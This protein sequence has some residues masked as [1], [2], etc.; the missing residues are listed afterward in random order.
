[1]FGAG[2]MF[3]PQVVKS[4]RVMKRAVEA[5]TPYI[6]AQSSKGKS[7][8]K[9]VMATVKGDVHDIGKNIV[10]VVTSCNGYEI[11]DLG[12]MVE[13]ETIA[14]EAQ[15]WG[16]DAIGL[17][18]LI[19][20]SLDEMIK[21]VKCL[22]SR[23]MKTDVIIG[24]ATTSELHTAVKIAPEYSGVVVHSRDASEN[25]RILSRLL[26]PDRESYIA[27]IKADQAAERELYLQKEALRTL[28]PIEQA[29]Q[30]AYCKRAED[31]IIP[32]HTGKVVFNNFSI[33][34][35]EKY[36]DWNFFFSSWEL[37]GRYPEILSSPEK[38]EQARHLF[39]DA[40]RMIDKI[41][42][43]KALTLNGT[44]GI[45]PAY[46]REDDIIVV[47]PKGETVLAQLRNQSS[48]AD[49]NLC[50][51]DYITEK[52]SGQDYIGMFAVSAGLGLKKLS[53][54][55]KDSGDD[56]GA[57]MCKLLADRL[58]EAFAE[59]VHEF[60][61]RTMWGYQKEELSVKDVLR[62]NYTGLRFAFGYPATPDH[63]QKREIFDILGVT[64]TTGMRL[65][66]NY[67]I[68]PGEALCGLIFSDPNAKYFTIGPIS[69]QQK[70]EY[71]SR[72]N[73]PLQT[74]EKLISKI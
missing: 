56:Y 62:G 12:V 27:Q 6:E 71:A 13:C 50:V 3:L 14:D 61:R 9:V 52:G 55:Y 37:K 59:T 63:S 36:I 41:K 20:P 38:G 54:G 65:T 68:D 66:E 1:M 72:R 49:Q 17:S 58:T 51:A 29:R 11:K 69:D 25:T 22:Q 74:I 8:G 15:K 33:E 60:V 45:Y 30:R 40:N 21:V 16:A 10:S 35:V 28:R 26:G 70:E 44:V 73:L 5:L 32:R 24:G 67:M 43:E 48:S 7:A 19:T 31:I 18:G 39:D 23:G 34:Q 42:S 64:Q 46:R 47:T 53:D 4:A 2:K 57:I